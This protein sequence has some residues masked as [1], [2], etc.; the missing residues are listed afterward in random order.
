MVDGDPFGEDLSIAMLQGELEVKIS[1]CNLLFCRIPVNPV[2][3]ERRDKL[4][5]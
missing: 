1:F 5:K 3:S 2:I 4:L